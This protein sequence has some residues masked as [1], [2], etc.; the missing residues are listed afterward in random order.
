MKMS[1]IFLIVLI[2][3]ILTASSN[4][5]HTVNYHNRIFFY[6]DERTNVLEEYN[7]YADKRSI[8]D[9]NWLLNEDANY[10]RDL[11]MKLHLTYGLL[12]LKFEESRNSSFFDI[13]FGVILIYVGYKGWKSSKE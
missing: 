8:E 12:A 13:F 5:Y 11:S 6:L 4:I 7:T 3:G 9:N 10:I 2:I 1:N